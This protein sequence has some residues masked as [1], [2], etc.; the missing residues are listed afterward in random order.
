MSLQSPAATKVLGALGLA[1]LALAGWLLVLG[2]QAEA[3]SITRIAI[4]DTRDQSDE[5]RLQLSALQKQERELPTT[6]AQ[7]RALEDL[8]PRTADQPGLFRQVSRAAS[9]ADIPPAQVTTVAPTAPVLGGS[10]TDGVALPAA[11]TSS[12]VARQIV[13]ITVE[14]DYA[15]TQRL[16]RNLEDMPRAYLVNS[17]SIGIGSAPGS[18]LTTLTGDMFVMPPAPRR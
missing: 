12:D 10:Q 14:A 2:P 16:L 1:V 6:M 5:L 13:T 9:Q 4:T 8:F 17:L 3:L 18:L 7:D 11:S 15:R